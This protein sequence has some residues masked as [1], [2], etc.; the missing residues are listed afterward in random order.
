M[1][2]RPSPAQVPSFAAQPLPP[3]IASAQQPGSSRAAVATPALSPPTTNAT[4]PIHVCTNPSFMRTILRTY[5]AVV[6]FFT[7]ASCGPCRMIAPVF[8]SLAEAKA[9]GRTNKIAFVKVDLDV[10][11]NG[12]VAREHGTRVTPTFIFFL[13]GQKVCWPVFYEIKSLHGR[14]TGS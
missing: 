12:A 10:G 1:F 11:M 14:V 2:G 5:N 13:N 9:G 8:E 7:S 6:A 3:Q 4:S